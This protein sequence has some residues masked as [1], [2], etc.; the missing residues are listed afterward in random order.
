M[1]SRQARISS[2]DEYIASHPPD[3]QAILK[4]IRAGIRKASPTAQEVI[5]Y[6]MPAFT[7]NGI[8]VYFAAFKHHIG[9][10]PP[11]HGGNERLRKKKAPYE[12]PK[13]NLIFPLNQPIPYAPI[14]SIVKLR[15]R[16]NLAEVA[17]ERKGKGRSR[18]S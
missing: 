14:T 18:T 8:L 13:G 3:I 10:Y 1:S 17:A 11:I 4:N 6:R 2:I 16:Q 9:L 12:G 7:L 15:A 5:S